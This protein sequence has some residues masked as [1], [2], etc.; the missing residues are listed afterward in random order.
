[1]DLNIYEDR[2]NERIEYLKE[3]LGNIRAGRANPQILNKIMVEY[4][5]VPTPLNQVAAISVPEARQILIAPWDRN[6]LNEISRAISKA[7]I[8]INPQNDGTGIRLIFPELN[9]SRR[10]EIVKDVNKMGEDTKVQIR[11]IRRD[12]IDDVKKS[13]K[14]DNLSED[15]VHSLEEKIQKITDKLVEKVTAVVGEKEKE[16]MEI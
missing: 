13:Q 6:L 2:M 15:E 10:R 4:Y 11:N 8:G 9:A 5:G 7:D 3:E 12:A 14:E 16:I 1:M